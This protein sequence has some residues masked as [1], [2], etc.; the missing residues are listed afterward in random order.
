M[1]SDKPVGTEGEKMNTNGVHHVE[2]EADSETSFGG[3]QDG[4]LDRLGMKMDDTLH[5]VFTAYVFEFPNR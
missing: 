2:D 3:E 1:R 5:R 4:F